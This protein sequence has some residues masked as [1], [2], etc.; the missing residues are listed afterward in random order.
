MDRSLWTN[1]VGL[2]LQ[3]QRFFALEAEYRY[4][5]LLLGGNFPFDGVALGWRGAILPDSSRWWSDLY[6]RA[7]V[8]TRNVMGARETSYLGLYLHPGWAFSLTSFLKLDAEMALAYQFGDM[9]HNYLGANLGVR[10]VF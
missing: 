10:F 9:A 1:D 5:A 3:W 4:G 6:L 2:S 7:G 8:Q